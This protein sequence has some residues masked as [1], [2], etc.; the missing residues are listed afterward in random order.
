MVPTV[1]EMSRDLEGFLTGIW[2]SVANAVE[3]FER[4]P[5]DDKLDYSRRTMASIINDFM[6]SNARKEFPE[7]SDVRWYDRR[8]QFLLCIKGKYR[9]KFKKLD[10]GLRPSNIP[11]MQAL[12]FLHQGMLPSRG[13]IQL[14]LPGM[15]PPMTNLVAGYRWSAVGEKPDIF[16]VCPNGSD[17]AWEHKLEGPPSPENVHVLEVEVA[18]STERERKPRVTAKKTVAE[19]LPG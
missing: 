10:R 8:G 5:S 2:R 13:H 6:V 4:L 3:R 19:K 14:L 9:I 7:G 17:N 18:E 12:E 1:E 11:T 15:P 16:M